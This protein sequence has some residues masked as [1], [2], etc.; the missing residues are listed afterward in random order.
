MKIVVVVIISVGHAWTENSQ[1]QFIIQ[2]SFSTI[3]LWGIPLHVLIPWE[4][5]S[6]LPLT[7]IHIHIAL[8]AT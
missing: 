4:C 8:K 5:L 6:W 2:A 7:C 1:L 3:N